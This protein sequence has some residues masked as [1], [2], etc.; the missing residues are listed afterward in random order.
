[1]FLF[2]LYG[3]S[4]QFWNTQVSTS[5]FLGFRNFDWLGI[6]RVVFSH[7]LVDVFKKQ[8]ILEY[9]ILVSYEALIPQIYN[10]GSA[11]LRSFSINNRGLNAVLYES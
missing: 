6:L 3:D 5:H 8:L 1:M 2:Y 11:K 10:T 9:E 4:G 7:A